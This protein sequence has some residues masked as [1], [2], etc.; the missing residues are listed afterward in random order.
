MADNPAGGKK[1]ARPVKQSASEY[2]RSLRPKFL[3]WRPPTEEEKALAVRARREARDAELLRVTELAKAR[4][5][6]RSIARKS[7][8]GAAPRQG[9]RKRG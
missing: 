6:E 3:D 8:P 5:L 4:D 7:D 1:P 2:L 9:R